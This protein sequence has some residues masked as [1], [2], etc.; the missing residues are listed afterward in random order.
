MDEDDNP[1]VLHNIG[2]PVLDEN[3]N[4][5]YENGTQYSG[6]Y[7]AQGYFTVNYPNAGLF[8]IELK[9]AVKDP[10]GEYFDASKYQILI[11]DNSTD[12]AA[13]RPIKTNGETITINTVYFRITAAA[14]QDGAQH[15]AQIN[16]LFKPDGSDEWISAYSE[17]RANYALVIPATN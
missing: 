1:I 5:V 14:Y 12:P 16:I 3:G 7:P 9:P 13:F 15:K 10:Q 2:D 17:I 6:Y 11:Y 8:K 4:Q